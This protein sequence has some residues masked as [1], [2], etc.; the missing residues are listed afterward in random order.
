MRKNC[1]C[2]RSLK[3]VAQSTPVATTSLLPPL[4]VRCTNGVIRLCQVCLWSMRR[5]RGNHGQSICVAGRCAVLPRFSEHGDV[6]TALIFASYGQLELLRSC[7]LVYIDATFRVV[8]QLFTVFVQHTDHSFPVTYLTMIR[9]TTTLYQGVFEKLHALIKKY[10]KL[11]TTCEVHHLAF[12]TCLFSRF[13]VLQFGA[14]FSR[15]TFSESD[16]A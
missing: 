4:K 5:P 8:P 6:Y 15:P 1:L 10:N 11:N 9:K 13:L 7:R 14:A 2:G 12:H 16:H 3:C